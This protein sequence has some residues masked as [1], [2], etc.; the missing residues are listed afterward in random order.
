MPKNNS[1]K[2]DSALAAGSV[3]DLDIES[4]VQKAVVA[5]VAV[6]EAQLRQLLNDGLS[7]FRS[8]MASI[9][10]GLNQLEE[11]MS[12]VEDTL[13]NYTVS[14][15]SE[16]RFNKE[17]E[18][19]R[20]ET[21]KETRQSLLLAND[22]E[23]YVRLNN[24]RICGLAVGKNADCR[25]SVIEFLAQKMNIHDVRESDIEAAHSIMTS[26]HN[27]TDDAQ[28]SMQARSKVSIVRFINR[29]QR[30]MIIR[31]RKILK[32]TGFSITEDLTSLNVKT[33][34]RLRN[35]HQV[36]STWTWGGRVFALLQNGKKVLVRPFQPVS[37]LL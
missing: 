22:N 16:E 26:D 10:T 5:A 11:R 1:N 9:E 35:D 6:F 18:S 29:Y 14:S 30:D 32:G 24:L 20:Q 13:T 3:C 25:K 8:R 7:E 4:I 36:L 21:R 37:E 34:N 27:P 28:A 17:L 31:N 2:T 23:Q 12:K 19:I 15:P 33:V